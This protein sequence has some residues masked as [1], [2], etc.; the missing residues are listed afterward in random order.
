MD[1]LESQR[2]VCFRLTAEMNGKTNNYVVMT[3]RNRAS[4]VMTGRNIFRKKLYKA[5]KGERMK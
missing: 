4:W 5:V 2:C 3:S 1:Y